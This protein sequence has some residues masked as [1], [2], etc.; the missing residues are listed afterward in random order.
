[1]CLGHGVCNRLTSDL[2]MESCCL[3]SQLLLPCSGFKASGC[4]VRVW[5]SINLVATQDPLKYCSSGVV[6][7]V[8][9]SK[10]WPSLPFVVVIESDCC[11]HCSLLLTMEGV[12]LANGSN[13]EGQLD[14]K[15]SNEVAK[16]LRPAFGVHSTIRSRCSSAEVV[17][18][19]RDSAA[20]CC[21]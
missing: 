2:S 5:K 17:Q 7:V 1:M 11:K 20:R 19:L 13:L 14:G 16:S 15:A 10:Y 8:F 9:H 21:C 6:T 18:M 12:V 3:S 4:N